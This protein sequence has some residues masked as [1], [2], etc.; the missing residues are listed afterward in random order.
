MKQVIINADDFGYSL[1]VNRGVIKAFKDG[2]VSSTTLMANMPGCQEAI[3]LAKENPTLGV[4]CHLNITAGKPLTTA[5]TLV[6]ENGE[7]YHLPGYE[8]HRETM[9]PEE[10]YQE[11]CAQV[12][13]LLEQGIKL[14]HLDSHHHTHSFAENL[15]ITE[16]ISAK[17]Q[18]PVR[19]CYD[20]EK[21]CKLDFQRGIAGFD[22]LMNY[23][24]I[25]SLEK[26]YHADQEQCL[27]E[28]QVVLDRLTENEITELMVHP[29]FV[30]ETLYFTS[31]FNVPRIKE[32]A[33]LCDSA[34]KTKLRENEI[35]VIPYPA[36]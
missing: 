29:A 11:W 4:G 24:H 26:S 15:E 5:K 14:T 20:I 32:V 6:D 27:Q 33:I 31:S 9:D 10:I 23:P 30:D 35:E 12:D 13:Y 28:I 18:L 16:R 8:A 25:R 17:Y 19:N 7:F 1:A 2:M 3:Q 34:F 22:D 21:Q 36:A